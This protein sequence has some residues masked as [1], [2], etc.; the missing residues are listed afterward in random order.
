M[1]CSP[2]NGEPCLHGSECHEGVLVKRRLSR[3]LYISATRTSVLAIGVPSQHRLSI[4]AHR[5]PTMV[6]HDPPTFMTLPTEIRLSIL[7]FAI[8]ANTKAAKKYTE[9]G[10][11]LHDHASF[12]L[13]DRPLLFVNKT[14]HTEVESLLCPRRLFCWSLPKNDNHRKE[15]LRRAI[16]DLGWDEVWVLERRDVGM[17]IR[18]GWQSMEEVPE[19]NFM[20]PEYQQLRIAMRVWKEEADAVSAGCEMEVGTGVTVRARNVLVWYVYFRGKW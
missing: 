8:D 4:A 16:S 10:R 19:A 18:L 11:F 7:S 3:L 13:P 15:R 2:G 9:Q 12:F 1:T 17:Q 6:N 14:L 20:A 5:P